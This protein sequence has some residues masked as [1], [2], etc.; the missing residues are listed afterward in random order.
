MIKLEDD[1]VWKHVLDRLNDIG[2]EKLYF[3]QKKSIHIVFQNLKFKKFVK[4]DLT[5]YF[6][7]MNQLSKFCIG[8][9]FNYDFNNIDFSN[10]EDGSLIECCNHQTIKLY[11]QAFEKILPEISDTMKKKSYLRDQNYP[12]TP[13]EY[14]ISR[15][16]N[17]Y[18]GKVLNRN[19]KLIN[20]YSHCLYK[21]DF[22][23]NIE[24]IEPTI[25]FELSGFCYI[26]ENRE[27]LGKKKIKINLLE[28]YDFIPIYFDMG[29]PYIQNLLGIANRNKNVHIK[30][31]EN[32]AELMNKELI[33]KH[34]INLGYGSTKLKW[35]KKDSKSFANGPPKP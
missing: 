20:E 3:F 5:P 29:L 33:E 8:I 21:V 7:L 31:I 19:V 32:I 24:G 1:E 27:L 23:I 30:L 6:K 34:N 12:Q 18:L 17:F 4:I 10:I 2:Y 9:K 11:Q 28:N 25:A 14:L 26:F 13:Q 15:S 35:M 22:L 16:L